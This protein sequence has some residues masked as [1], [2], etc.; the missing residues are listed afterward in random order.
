MAHRYSLRGWLEVSQ[1]NLGAIAGTIDKFRQ[2]YAEDTQWGIY[3]KGW[4]WNNTHANGTN[5]V[6]YGADVQEEGLNVLEAVLDAISALGVEVDGYFHAQGEDGET[7]F[8]YRVLN[9]VW[10]A[11]QT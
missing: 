7:N 10:S 11:E 3:L 2:Q 4:C 5:F 9:G 8:V 6:F 1:D